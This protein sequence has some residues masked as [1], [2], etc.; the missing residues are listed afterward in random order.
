MSDEVHVSVWVGDGT[1]LMSFSAPSYPNY[2]EGQILYLERDISPNSPEI[3][4]KN[5]EPIRLTK[6]RIVKINHTV[7]QM[8]SANKPSS[9]NPFPFKINERLGM[10]V[11]VKKA[12]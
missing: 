1:E 5:N 12:K 11:Y 8:F 3:I 10:E 9:E 6:Y 7:R 2:H 4:I